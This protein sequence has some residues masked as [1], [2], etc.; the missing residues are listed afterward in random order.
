V[1]F[2]VLLRRMQMTQP[3]HLHISTLLLHPYPSHL[4]CQAE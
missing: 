2:T 1:P 4:Q 3:E